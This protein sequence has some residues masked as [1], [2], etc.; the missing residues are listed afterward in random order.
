VVPRL[1]LHFPSSHDL[2]DTPTPHPACQNAVALALA[3]V[4]AHHPA[5]HPNTPSRLSDDCRLA[6]RGGGDGLAVPGLG[7]HL[8]FSIVGP[9]TR[10]ILLGTHTIVRSSL[11]S[12]RNRARPLLSGPHQSSLP[13]T[14]S[15]T[16]AARV[17]GG[18]LL[19]LRGRADPPPGQAPR[20]PLQPAATLGGGAVA[21]GALSRTRTHR[22]AVSRMCSDTFRVLLRTGRAVLTLPVPLSRGGQSALAPLPSVSVPRCFQSFAPDWSHCVDP[23]RR[24]HH[25]CLAPA[26]PLSSVACP[27]APSRGSQGETRRCAITRLSHPSARAPSAPPHFPAPRPFPSAWGSATTSSWRSARR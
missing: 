26:P 23:S 22:R 8:H 2:P 6:G 15:G 21:A 19:S 13:N 25:C 12:H 11:R 24:L 4:S 16:T 27:R 1:C 7:L 3:V 18:E 10:P 17:G 20:G 14:T 5:Q 9:I